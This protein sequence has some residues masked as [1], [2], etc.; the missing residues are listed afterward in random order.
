M[1]A[2]MN[3]VVNGGPAEPG[4]L[5]TPWSLIPPETKPYRGKDLIRDCLSDGD[6]TVYDII[7]KVRQFTLKSDG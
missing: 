1:S 6:P 3:G 7:L 5:K 4:V 2:V